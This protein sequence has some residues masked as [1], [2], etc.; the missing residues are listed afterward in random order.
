MAFSLASGLGKVT[1]APV[2]VEG[3]LGLGM[4]VMALVMIGWVHLIAT[5]LLLRGY[6]LAGVLAL[7]IPYPYA[8]V[9][10]LKAEAYGMA[11]MIALV[12][13]L[14]FMVWKRGA[15]QAPH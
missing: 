11:G 9:L 8:L 15:R 7:T 2:E 4:P 13:V 12:T 10:A 6:R 14:A 1:R 5:V 3:A